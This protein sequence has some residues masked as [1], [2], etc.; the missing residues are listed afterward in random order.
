M[1]SWPLQDAKARLSEV[2]NKAK[3]DG[4]QIITRH[5]VEEVAVVP[6]EQWKLMNRPAGMT[7]LEALQA[8]PQFELDIPPRGRLRLRN[9]VKF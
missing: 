5:G 6:I 8:G 7:L 1:G 9:P 4:P 3:R 2:V